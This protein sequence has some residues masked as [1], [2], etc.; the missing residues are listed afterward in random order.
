MPAMKTTELSHPTSLSLPSYRQ[1]LIFF[2]PLALSNSI[3][4][5]ESLIINTALSRAINSELNL[6]A[7]SVMF[8]IALVV[9]AP[10]T[11]LSSAA[12]ALVRTRPSFQRLFRFSII[13]GAITSAIGFTVALTPLYNWLVIDIMHI[14]AQVAHIARPAQIII[15]FWPFPVAWRRILQ[16]ALIAHD[17]TPVVARATAVRLGVLGISL[18]VSSHLFPDRMLLAAA[19]AMQLS[20]ISEAVFVS[21]AAFKV[22]RQL[23]ERESKPLFDWRWLIGFY[24]PLAAMSILRMIA[25]PILTAGV[26]AGQMPERSL[27]AWSVAWS[28]TILPFGITAG[29]EQVA[30]AKGNG[31]AAR[32]RVRRFV[33]GIGL[34]LSAI[35]ALVVMT[36]LVDPTLELLFD[37]LPEIKPLVIMALR[38]MA[39]MPLMQSMQGMGRGTAIGDER[40][41]DTRTALALALL[42]TIA[43]TVIGPRVTSL[44]GVLIG[45]ACT[46]ASALAEVGWL[47]WSERRHAA[48][49]A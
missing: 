39:L 5:L 7:Y 43:V 18:L 37:P 13:L 4:M 45:V 48:R 24:Q 11:M 9:E 28:V 34:A 31:P 2:L 1:L 40:T 38:W 42:A 19:C 49:A 35:L 16:G 41:R 23:P 26:A 17:H 12:T 46:L 47:N 30:I 15:S 22:T 36:P 33:W 6:A 21:P 32:A 25:R 10:V 14:P 3:M 27:A 44:T 8:S 29:L 20:V